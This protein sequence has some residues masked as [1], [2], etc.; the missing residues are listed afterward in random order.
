MNFKTYSF[1]LVLL[2]LFIQVKAQKIPSKEWVRQQAMYIIKQPSTQLY[3]KEVLQKISS[4]QLFKANFDK[5]TD[6]VSYL[7]MCVPGNTA[8]LSKEHGR[9]VYFLMR[10]DYT[11]GNWQVS[12]YDQWYEVTEVADKTGDGLSEIVGISSRC[13]MDKCYFGYYLLSLAEGTASTLFELNGYDFEAA[14]KNFAPGD[15]IRYVPAVKFEDLNEDGINE[16]IVDSEVALMGEEKTIAT[17]YTSNT[18]ILTSELYYF[19]DEPMRYPQKVKDFFDR[20]EFLVRRED[21]RMMMAMFAPDYLKEQHQNMMGGN[22]AQFLNEFFCGNEVGNNGFKC[23]K[24]SDIE[25]MKRLYI[26]K[27]GSDYQARYRIISKG[28]VIEAFFTIVPVDENKFGLWGA[29]G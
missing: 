3:N 2:F 1:L 21:T 13:E 16:I 14:A 26:E 7:A 9:P 6:Q 8:R 12:W 19:M 18:A 20:F 4:I 5:S 28:Q 29:A 24:L 17:H 22:T 10:L 15:T 25:S 11:A 23:F 27:Q